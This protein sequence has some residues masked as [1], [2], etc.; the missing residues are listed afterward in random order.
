MIFV[1]IPLLDFCASAQFLKSLGSV[2]FGLA[3]VT[4]LGYYNFWRPIKNPGW[5]RILMYHNTS[6]DESACGM[7]IHPEILE[8]Q[9]QYLIARSYKFLKISDLPKITP[10][11]KH[12]ALTFDDGFASNYTYLFP[13][14]KKYQVFATIYLSPHIQAIEALNQAHI[15]EM[16]AS[17]L[18]EFGAHTLTHINLTKVDAALANQE[19]IASKRA[20]EQLT[21]ATC[22]TFAYPYGRYE[23]RHLEMVQAA[24][25]T[26]A[27]TTSKR[28]VAFKDSNP[29][30]LPRLSVSG[31]LNLLQF[32]LIL[33]R[34][35][36]KL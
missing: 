13:I 25:F 14:L 10:N 16:Q 35:R 27:V 8:K 24:G 26:T 11:T 22:L 6:P 23:P 28:I 31:K 3:T 18:V 36:Y 5:P 29:H 19:I 33:S 15:S 7:N 34:G 17:G 30:A 1:A 32:Y 9:I 20:V 2:F 21:G 4:L 12:V